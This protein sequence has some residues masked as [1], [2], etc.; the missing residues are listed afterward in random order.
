MVTNDR[1]EE[2]YCFQFGIWQHKVKF[3]GQLKQRWIH[4]WY[5]PNGWFQGGVK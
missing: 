3:L 4:V 5:H 2:K 1:L